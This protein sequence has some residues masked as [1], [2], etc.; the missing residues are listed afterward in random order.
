ME[1]SEASVLPELDAGPSGGTHT[2]PGLA[3]T[4]QLFSLTEISST[5]GVDLSPVGLVTISA[6]YMK[7]P[8]PGRFYLRTGQEKKKKVLMLIET[9]PRDHTAPL[10]GTD[11]G[12]LPISVSS[13][14]VAADPTSTRS[15]SFD[16]GDFSE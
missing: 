9:K 6:N 7:C 11:P 10:G 13:R 12:P 15:D 8:L 14:G 4:S 1:H 3:V 2:S 5:R 16:P